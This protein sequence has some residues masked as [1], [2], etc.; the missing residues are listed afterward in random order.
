MFVK[1]I[2]SSEPILTR[3]NPSDLELQNETYSSDGSESRCRGV[4]DEAEREEEPEREKVEIVA[5]VAR[6]L[7]IP[8]WGAARNN[9]I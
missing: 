8:V 2:V 1:T 9:E 6:G 3:L 4:D 7:G 5:P